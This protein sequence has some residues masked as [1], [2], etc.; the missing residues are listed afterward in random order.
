MNKSAQTH[1]ISG[2]FV[3][4]L[5]GIFALFSTVMVLMGAQAY[6]SSVDRLS[7]HNATRIAPAYVR[8][9]VR[10]DDEKGVIYIE[11][12][13]GIPCVT[14]LNTYDEEQYV[15]RVYCYDGTLREWFTSAEYAFV[16]EDGEKVC[17][18][19]EMNCEI[20]GGILYVGLRSGDSWTQVDITLRSQLGDVS[21][22]EVTE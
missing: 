22:N 19:D 18:L 8:S 16:P 17:D 1:S 11:E 21:A 6:K 12:A 14:M 13:E 3:F 20:R 5:L 15:T 9:M 7:M 2:M 4:V 10:G